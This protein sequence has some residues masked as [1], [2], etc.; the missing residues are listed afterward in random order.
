MERRYDTSSFTFGGE[1]WIAGGYNGTS[2]LSTIEIRDKNGFWNISSVELPVKVHS[3]CIVSLNENQIL[4][5]GGSLDNGA[6]LP[7][8]HLYDRRNNSWERKADMAGPLQQHS[9]SLLEEGKVL[10]AGGAAYRGGYS[11]SQ[12]F[13][14]ASNTWEEGP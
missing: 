14:V 12:I 10:V 7:T 6:I 5:T 8:T 2:R 13:D 11:N 9:C 3:H 4:L 1:F